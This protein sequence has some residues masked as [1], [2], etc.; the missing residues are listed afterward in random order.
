MPSAKSRGW[1]RG[2]WAAPEGA[3]A[4]GR[5]AGVA[6]AGRGVPT[7]PARKPTPG[8]RSRY[9]SGA[10]RTNKKRNAS[11]PCG[12]RTATPR[13]EAGARARRRSRRA[14]GTAVPPVAPPLSSPPSAPPPPPRVREAPSPPLPSF[15][16]TPP[17]P[18]RRARRRFPSPSRRARDTPAPLRRARLPEMQSDL[19]DPNRN[20]NRRTIVA[21]WHRRGDGESRLVADSHEATN[22]GRRRADDAPA[23]TEGGSGAGR[24]ESGRNEGDGASARCSDAPPH[25]GAARAR[26][27]ARLPR[28]RAWGRPRHRPLRPCTLAKATESA[29]AGG[30]GGADERGVLRTWKKRRRASR[31]LETKPRR[32]AGRHASGPPQPAAAPT[33]ERSR[34]GGRFVALR[35]PRVPVSSVVVERQSVLRAA[36]G[37]LVVGRSAARPLDPPLAPSHPSSPLVASTALPLPFPRSPPPGPGTPR[38]AL[39]LRPRPRHRRPPAAAARHRSSNAALSPPKRGIFVGCFNCVGAHSADRQIVR[40]VARSG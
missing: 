21:R 27:N 12:A 17:P 25:R 40:A 36:A 3:E 32:V 1:R 13:F 39:F 4:G 2:Q 11:D 34:V 16:P 10:Q 33:R 24:A 35:G 23:A 28:R 30:G 19:G 7:R 5:A 31:R 22:R 26:R 14:R 38:N 29:A 15:P 37:R 8:S 9:E 6:R 20:E 18:P